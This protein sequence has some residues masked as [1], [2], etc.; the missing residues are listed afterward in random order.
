M[1]MRGILENTGDNVV[2]H[3]EDIWITKISVPYCN[4]M[5]D[6][7]SDGGNS[8]LSLELSIFCRELFH[9]GGC[10]CHLFS[11]HLSH[12]ILLYPLN[13][14]GLLR[15]PGR[16]LFCLGSFATGDGL[17]T[18][19]S[20]KCIRTQLRPAVTWAKH[21]GPGPKPSSAHAVTA[22]TRA[23]GM[24]TCPYAN[25]EQM[26]LFSFAAHDSSK[27]EYLLCTNFSVMTKADQYTLIW[28]WCR[29]V[30]RDPKPLFL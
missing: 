28:Y 29:T 22:L 11:S 21:K 19:W 12:C 15:N 25:V 1:S 6:M 24:H 5:T 14:S 17:R 20:R 16:F 7:H 13:V 8:Y 9:C 26:G 18:S 10:H 3:V 23:M 27:A 30:D 4:A 2:Y